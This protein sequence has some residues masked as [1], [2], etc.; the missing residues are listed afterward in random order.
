MTLRTLVAATA[1]AACTFSISARAQT[2]VTTDPVGFMSVSLLG[3]SDTFVAPP[4]TRPPEFTGAI[5]SASGNSIT[6]SASPGWTTNQFVYAAGTQSKHYYALIATGGSGKEGHFYP[7]TGNSANALTVDTSADDLNNVPANAQVLVIPYWTF[8]TLF[9][10]S[11]QNVS[12]TPSPSNK[13]TQLKTQVLIPDYTTDG[14]NLAYTATYYFINN[15]VNNAPNVGW[16]LFGDS[17]ITDHGDDILL[18]DLYF[19]VRNP[20]GT[21]TLPLTNAGSVLTKKLA[22]QL[23]TDATQQ[24]DNP[25]AMVRPI[26]VTLNNTGLT[27]NDGSFV[28][29]PSNRLTQIK[30]Q[31][32]VY[33]N[34]VASFNKSPVATYYY[35]NNTV[36]GQPNVGW[37]LF[38]DSATNDHGGDLVAAASAITIRKAPSGTGA[39]AIWTNAP[40]Y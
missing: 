14:T 11:D 17:A 19:V 25:V 38:G 18:P 20:S 39:T 7:I 6:V 34:S 40:T 24:R 22:S 29:S 1:I 3:S 13:I 31:L 9:P 5:Q 30:D 4:F 26:G 16:R 27:P 35:I 8:A 21:P 32:Y 10:T 15:T 37:R 23:L 36:N 12:F 33:D 2:S 28:A